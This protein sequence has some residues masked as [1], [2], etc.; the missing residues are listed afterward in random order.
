MQLPPVRWEAIGS[1]AGA[2]ALGLSV[3]HHFK[4]EKGR[5]ASKAAAQSKLNTNVEQVLT[6]QA[7]L[8]EQQ[9]ALETRQVALET[10]Q[11]AVQKERRKKEYA[12]GVD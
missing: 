1:G 12:M 10:Q 7:A 3:H 11:A 8:L 4:S 2:A 6:Q 5:R 9:A